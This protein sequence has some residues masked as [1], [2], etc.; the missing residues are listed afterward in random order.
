MKSFLMALVLWCGVCGNANRTAITP[1]GFMKIPSNRNFYLVALLPVH[2]RG[3][4]FASCGPA[5]ESG[6]LDH[7]LSLSDALDQANE[8][9]VLRTGVRLGLLVLDSCS[10]PMTTADVLYRLATGEDQTFA[11]LSLQSIVAILTVEGGVMKATRELTSAL[12]LPHLYAPLR[13]EPPPTLE[14]ETEGVLFLGVDG[15]QWLHAV[16]DFLRAARLDVISLLYSSNVYG[17]AMR[18]NLL[19]LMADDAPSCVADAFPLGT[20]SPHRLAARLASRS[21]GR[22]VLVLTNEERSLKE[23]LRA[24]SDAHGP[25]VFLVDDNVISLDELVNPDNTSVSVLS[26]GLGSPALPDSFRNTSFHLTPEHPEPLPKAWVR[27]LWEQRFGCRWTPDPRRKAPPCDG[28]ERLNGTMASH[29]TLRRLFLSVQAA[30]LGLQNFLTRHCPLHDEAFEIDGCGRSARDLLTQEIR[31]AVLGD[32][33]RG[34]KPLLSNSEGNRELVFLLH[35]PPLQP[36]RKLASWHNGILSATESIPAALR[37]LGVLEF[38]CVETCA[39]ACPS[40]AAVEKLVVLDPAAYFNQP[41]GWVMSG[42]SALGMVAVIGC[43]AYFVLV[44]P[45]TRG[46]TLLGYVILVGVFIVFGSNFAFVAAPTPASCAARRLLTGFAFAL[47]YS[48]KLVKVV[49]V[50]HKGRLPSQADSDSSLAGRPTPVSSLVRTLPRRPDVSPAVA[51]L[52][53]LAVAAFQAAIAIAWLVLSP[54]NVL[55]ATDGI[56]LCFPG[57]KFEAHLAVSFLYVLVLLCLGVAFCLLAWN[58]DANGREPRW[59]LASS[60]VTLLAW[61]VGASVAV[62][63]SIDER[64]LP[65]ILAN[66]ISASATLL[67]LFAPKIRLYSTLLSKANQLD[68][69]ALYPASLRRRRSP[70]RPPLATLYDPLHSNYSSNNGTMTTG[71]TEIPHVKRSAPPAPDIVKGVPVRRT[72]SAESRPRRPAYD[73]GSQFLAPQRGTMQG[74]LYSQ[75]TINPLQYT[76]KIIHN[77]APPKGFSSPSRNVEYF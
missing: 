50:W 8:E 61:L 53:A 47:V 73:G 4:S 72:P 46:P 19:A 55:P 15:G 7:L 26:L 29:A 40:Q 59:I 14:P 20:D 31:K 24:Y 32:K 2:P 18:R 64:S 69:R 25:G 52:V 48:A 38:P 22:L 27:E 36:R 66:W 21:H 74:G 16:V 71:S 51:V 76:N 62:Q 77:S 56:P 63:T 11:P 57:L 6:P 49:N 30:S 70:S 75:Q 67:C 39:E 12:H 5:N 58:S 44:S 35:S 60:L 10:Q 3:T 9:A 65:I 23:F 33:K 45:N 42:L 13:L 17:A 68:V 34:Q 37:R 28:H 1:V 41:W 43:L 54:P